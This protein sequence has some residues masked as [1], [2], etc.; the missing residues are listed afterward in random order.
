MRETNPTGQ[1]KRSNT[2]MKNGF[3][4]NL[5]FVPAAAPRLTA[6]VAVWAICFP[7]ATDVSCSESRNPSGEAVVGATA[8][9]D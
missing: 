6:S 8:W 7:A 1:Q 5:F 2:P 4:H 9:G 3:S